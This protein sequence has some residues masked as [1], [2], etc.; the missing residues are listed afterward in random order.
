MPVKHMGVEFKTP[1][2]ILEEMAPKKEAE[3]APAERAPPIEAKPAEVPWALTKED[4]ELLREY[5]KKAAEAMRRG[6]EVEREIVEKAK[7]VFEKIGRFVRELVEKGKPKTVKEALEK[8][9]IPIAKPEV[10]KE[11]AK[12]LEKELGIEVL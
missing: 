1:A 5:V 12:R 2:D 3:M 6:A 4:I 11:R 8:A 9:G 7:P 10:E